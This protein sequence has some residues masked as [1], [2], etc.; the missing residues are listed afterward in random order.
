MKLRRLRNSL[1]ALSLGAVF[2]MVRQAAA[3]LP[4]LTSIDDF[5]LA[6]TQ[7][8][9]LDPTN[10]PYHDPIT[11]NNVCSFCHSD[12]GNSNV[13]PIHQ[14][15]SGSMMAQATRDPL[16]RA[17]MQIANS[18]AYDVGDMCI[19]CHSPKGWLEGRSIPTDGAF[20]TMEDR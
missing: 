2:G 4:L 15:W 9:A 13:A 20:L 19:R 5:H 3:Q 14:D 8:G 7:H 10:P 18:D 12:F 16:F 6:G 1:L 17:C 11:T